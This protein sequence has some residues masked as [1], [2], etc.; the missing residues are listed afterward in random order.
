MSGREMAWFC[1]YTPVE[2]LMAAGFRPARRFGDPHGLEAADT[3][4]HPALC[5]YVRACLA[6]AL[7]R[8]PPHHA[9]FVNCCDGMRRLYDAWKVLFPESFT[10]LMDLPRRTDYRGREMLVMEF[11]RLLSS[12]EEF[13]DVDVTADDLR[14]ACRE[15]HELRLS[16]R[17]SAEGTDGSARVELAQ[18]IQETC[19]PVEKVGDWGNGVPVLLTG[20]LL[21]PQGLISALQRA[22]AR[23]VWADLCN[24]DRPFTAHEPVEGEDIPRILEALAAQYLERHPC[25]RM[26]ERERRYRLLLERIRECGARGVVY[27]SLKFCD[28]YLYD[29]PQLRERLREE[30]IPLLRLESD[31]ADGHAG[32]LLTRIEAFLEM[33]AE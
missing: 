30:G 9:V 14:Q 11:R 29:F 13:A 10:F 26:V 31:Y 2:V 22:G 6:Q 28:S 16:Y 32:Q 33:I 20:N 1:A 3:H 25:A 27:A 8:R 23:V 21:N 19:A 24:G 15:Y 7:D 5:P 12:L 18:Y 17:R 4:L